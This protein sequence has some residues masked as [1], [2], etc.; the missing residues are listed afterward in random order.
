VALERA[1][2]ELRLDQCIPALEGS[3]VRRVIIL[4]NVYNCHH[5]TFSD[6]KNHK[7]HTLKQHRRKLY[8]C[9]HCGIETKS[10]LIH[11]NYVLFYDDL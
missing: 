8:P 3:R 6:G 7:V 10:E 4:P 9:I 2:V 1:S 11:Q 5:E